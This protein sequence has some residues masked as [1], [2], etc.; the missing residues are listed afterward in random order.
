M[1]MNVRILKIAARALRR[2]VLRSALTCL[3]VVIGVA[4]V[5][6]MVEIGEGSAYAL[7]RTIAGL[8][9]NVIQ[10]DP[11]ASNIGGVSSGKGGRVTLTAEDCDALLREC[12]TLTNAAPGVDCRAQVVY[13]GR[14]WSP[15]NILGTS[16][17]F[18]TVRNWA[19]TA[20]GEPITEEDVRSA[21][22]VCMLGQTVARELFGGVSPVGKQVRVKN[23]SMKVV[24]VLGRKGANMSGRD[25]DD[26]VIAPWTTV[27]FRLAGVR[28]LSAA[29]VGS[30]SGGGSGS[31]S[32]YPSGA[33][34]LYPQQTASQAA[35]LPQT[36]RFADLDDIWVAADS[37]QDISL[38]MRQITAV[39][40]QRHHLLADAPDDFRIRDLTEISQAMGSTSRLMANL[41]LSIA[42]ISLVV[43]G[44][45]I[46]NIMLVSVTE[47]T[48]EIGLRMAVGARSRDILSQFLT[49]AVMLCMAGGL[50]GIALGRGASIAVTAFL[51]W[52]TIP[53]MS[54]VAA[55]V[56][57]AGIVGIVFG[58]YPAWKASRLDPIE[59]LRHE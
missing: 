16:P 43:G 21:A 17:A 32:L 15:N 20:E 23:L 57:V 40:R 6:T 50:L 27:K 48:K 45:G 36:T 54:A 29:P 18:L 34:Q 14:N 4:T 42:L 10:I 49:E 8:G 2:N 12:D 39:L 22:S 19:E 28:Q 47:R 55:A 52:P 51:R 53:S 7:K 41:L 31:G 9:S 44:V 11:S 59:A 13:G 38:A 33:V 35:D 58:F 3:G 24:G 46:M 37:P 26:L 1:T 25:Q 5:I 30:T 56:G